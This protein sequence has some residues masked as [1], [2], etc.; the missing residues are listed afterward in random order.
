M[1][2]TLPQQNDYP[3]EI[4]DWSAL[5][6]HNKRCLRKQNSQLVAKKLNLNRI[7]QSYLNCTKNYLSYLNS[8]ENALREMNFVSKT[9]SDSDIKNIRMDV[10]AIYLKLFQDVSNNNFSKVSICTTK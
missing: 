2:L 5:S 8:V 10:E 1:Q 6:Q 3:N 4:D 9:L 7:Y